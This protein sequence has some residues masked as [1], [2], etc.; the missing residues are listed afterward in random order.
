MQLP[1]HYSLLTILCLSTLLG[2]YLSPRQKS[3]NCLFTSASSVNPQ[4]LH[5][6]YWHFSMLKLF[7]D[8]F[9]Q[10]YYCC[11]LSQRVL[12]TKLAFHPHHC[13]YMTAWFQLCS[14]AV[15]Y[16]TS[17]VAHWTTQWTCHEVALAMPFCYE[18]V[19]CGKF[20][21]SVDLW[22]GSCVTEGLSAKSN[23]IN[24]QWLL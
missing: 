24:N 12:G 20:S 19:D 22:L 7:S 18:I 16:C 15:C 17:V 11:V 3:L 9:Q 6:E 21:V 23:S 2:P 1:S 4:L 8:H 10:K 13:R 14:W 5:L